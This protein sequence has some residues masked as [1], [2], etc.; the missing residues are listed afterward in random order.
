MHRNISF[1]HDLLSENAQITCFVKLFITHNS[2]FSVD[3]FL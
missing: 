2:L 1:V 3:N